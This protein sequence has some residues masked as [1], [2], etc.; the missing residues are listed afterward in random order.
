MSSTLRR[1]KVA[2]LQRC[3][4][5]E[6][7]RIQIHIP[8]TGEDR[9]RRQVPNGTQ[10]ALPELALVAFHSSIVRNLKSNSQQLWKSHFL[11]MTPVFTSP[12]VHC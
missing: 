5:A 1:R 7:N 10:T 12:T 9:R 2:H 3:D 4:Q 11:H 8:R 6:A